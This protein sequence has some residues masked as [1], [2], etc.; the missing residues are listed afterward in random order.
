MILDDNFLP[1]M[2][3]GDIEQRVLIGTDIPWSLAYNTDVDPGPLGRQATQNSYQ[4]AAGLIADSPAHQYF[5][6]VFKA[7]C[8]QHKIEYKEIYRIKLNWLPQSYNK[9]DAGDGWHVPHV[10]MGDDHKVFLYYVNDADGPTIF[11]KETYD[12]WDGESKLTVDTR[13][14]PKAGRGVMFDGKT[15]HASSSPMESP[16]RIIINVDFT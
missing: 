5:M 3:V 1:P 13:V 6:N 16:Y 8:K 10:D 9:D 15:Y 14:D 4:F 2:A 7:F 12:N 11:F